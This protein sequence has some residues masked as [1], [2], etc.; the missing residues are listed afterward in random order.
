MRSKGLPHRFRPRDW[1]IGVKLLFGFGL[2]ALVTLGLAAVNL[3]RFVS[4]QRTVDKAIN[5]GLR[6]QSLSTQIQNDLAAARQQEQSFLLRWQEEGYQQAASTYLIPFGGHISHI[7]RQIDELEGLIVGQPNIPAQ[8]QEAPQQLAIAVDAYRDEFGQ[9]TDLLHD[10]GDRDSGVIGEL[11]DAASDLERAVSRLEQTELSNAFL[12]LRASEMRYRLDGDP[13]ARSQTRIAL[14]QLRAMINWLL[15]DQAEQFDPLLTRYEQAFDELIAIDAAIAQHIAAYTDA[16]NTVRF[17]VLEIAAAGTA[18]ADADLSR[19]TAGVQQASRLTFLAIGLSVILSVFLAWLFTRQIGQPIQSLAESAH[20][21]ER[22]NLAVHAPV[23]SR[24]EIGTLAQ[25]F[26]SMAVQIRDLIAGLEQRVADRTRALEKRAALLATAA[27]VGQT[28]TSILELESLTRRVVE[29]IR[30]RFDL[31]YAGLF[32]IDETSA[33][34][35]EDNEYAVLVAGTGE[36]GQR[37]K[38]QGHKLRVGGASMVGAACAHKE[39]RLALDVADPSSSAEIVR[40]DNPLLPETR[41]EMALPLIVGERVLGALD[42]QSTKPA[43]FSQEDIAVLQLVANQIAVAVDNARKFSEEATLLEATSPLYRVSR[44]LTTAATTDEVVQV[45]IEAV[46]DTEA[47]GCMIARFDQTGRDMD[48]IQAVTFLGHWRRH[49]EFQIPIGQPLPPENINLQ[50]LTTFWITEDVEQD[51]HFS[52]SFRRFLLQREVRSLVNIPLRVGTRFIGF[53][54]IF[55]SVPGPFSLVALRL[56]ETL[57]DQAAVALERGRLLENAQQQAER[58]RAIRD[59]ADRV[60]SS[61][62][63]DTILRTTLENLS[64]VVSAEGGY[65]ELGVSKERTSAQEEEA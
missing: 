3:Y 49:G 50:A 56:Y 39:P 4:V 10:R 9:V 25:A 57:A 55:R 36:A 61:F 13:V 20:Q 45:I 29:L 47:D 15:P 23:R 58:E 60:T 41:S 65:I 63:I 64:T 59:L 28:V 7:H 22:G 37:L 2:M 30:E 17:L 21:I 46:A 53:I 5:E 6:I 18:L 44:R 24:D 26:N 34:P 1:P 42:V 51:T 14:A 62:D 16:V 32:L 40:F 12:Q 35:D 31:Y 19:I 11:E 43:A 52:D 8:A 48:Q 33:G 38:E 54:A 27:D